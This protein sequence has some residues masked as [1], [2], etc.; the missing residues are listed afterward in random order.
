MFQ[1]LKTPANALAMNLF[2]ISIATFNIIDTKKWIDPLVYDY[3]PL[4]NEAFSKNF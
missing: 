2:L 4:E 1:A 3:Q